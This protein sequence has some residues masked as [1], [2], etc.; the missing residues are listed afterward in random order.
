M[1]DRPKV[2][3]AACT[4]TMRCARRPFASSTQ[5]NGSRG[6]N[7][8][9]SAR[10]GG[11]LRSA[12]RRSM[13]Q[14]IRGLGRRAEGSR[15]GAGDEVIVPSHTYISSATCI[16]LMGLTRFLLRSNPGT[17][18]SRL[19]PSKQHT[20]RTPKRSSPSIC[21][22]SRWPARSSSGAVPRLACDRRRCARARRLP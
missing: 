4:S 9:P 16:E 2:P 12:W 15:R 3:L 22:V 7:R 14:W 5:A 13:Q 11:V 20:P 10:V 17:T 6:Q 8:R 21:T 19:T 18:P 1:D